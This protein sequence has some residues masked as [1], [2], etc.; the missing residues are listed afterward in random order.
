MEVEWSED[1]EGELVEM[2][3]VAPC[4]FDIANKG[5]SNRTKKRAAIQEI[6]TKLEMS[7]TVDVLFL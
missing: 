1:K 7:G 3:S 2:W 4:L 5:Y 6:A